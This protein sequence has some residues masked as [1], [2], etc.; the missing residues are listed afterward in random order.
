[1]TMFRKLHSP[2]TQ[3]E[4]NP[5][6]MSFSDIMAGILII[7]ILVCCALVYKL[8]E[9]EE[10]VSA[11][12]KQLE[13]DLR[14]RDAMLKEVRELLEAQHL[15]V[16]VEDDSI[17]VP[18]S[19]L[20]FASGSYRISTGKNEHAAEALGQALCDVLSKNE[21]WRRLE[22]IFVEG[23]TDS[24]S[25]DN[26][27]R[28]GNWELS[29]LR[30][31][32]LWKFWTEERPEEFGLAL[33]SMRHV[34]ESDGQQKQAALFS[35]SGYADTR[36]REME[37]ITE[38]QRCRNRRINIRFVTKQIMPEQLEKIRRPLGKIR[39]LGDD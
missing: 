23:H 39:E 12:I 8:S 26:R 11:N 28:M 18:I 16:E 7:F 24:V 38:E 19:T 32:S 34:Y 3:E 35:V 29:T 5:Y 27:Y 30:A 37:D 33:K 36:R 6:W 20:D 22:T 13:D 9:M 31:I 17:I 10:Q 14:V 1:M 4:D 25:A 15:H 21:R 2:R